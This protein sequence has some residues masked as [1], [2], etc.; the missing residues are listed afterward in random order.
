MKSF[1]ALLHFLT[2]NIAVKVR[3]FYKGEGAV[4][5]TRETNRKLIVTL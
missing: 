1:D 3:A 5:V 2:F 4:G